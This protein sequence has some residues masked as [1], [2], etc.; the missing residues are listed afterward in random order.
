MN[1]DSYVAPETTVIMLSA[2]SPMLQGSTGDGFST[3]PW[4]KDPDTL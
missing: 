4:K 1:K 3:S 2:E